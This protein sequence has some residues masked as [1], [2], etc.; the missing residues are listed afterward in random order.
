M[1][2]ISSYGP[3]MGLIWF[4]QGWS[5]FAK[6]FVRLSLLFMLVSMLMP[7]VTMLPIIGILLGILFIPL[8]QM[9]I[10]NAAYGIRLRGYFLLSDLS[11]KLRT[12]QVWGRLLLASFV[13]LFLT[14][15]IL[16]FT[17]P[18]IPISSDAIINIP[19][20]QAAEI[21]AST[22]S[23]ENLWVPLFCVTVYLLLSFWTYPLI[24]WEELPVSRAFLLSFKASMS[25]ALAL[26]LLLILFIAIAIGLL[27]ITK[28]LLFSLSNTLLSTISLFVFNTL[29]VGL[30]MSLFA[31]YMEMFYGKNNT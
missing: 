6:Q 2:N 29:L 15:F 12:P 16:N 31:A 13:N 24:C 3:G 25:N 10:F 7:M 9:L 17:L 20:E 19:A 1:P 26:S 22:F 11:Q 4:K 28:S 27:F 21:I 8:S 30:Y 23:L 14:Y 5:L 18:V